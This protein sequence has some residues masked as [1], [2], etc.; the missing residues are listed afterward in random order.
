VLVVIETRAVASS[1]SA[2]RRSPS[3][4]ST[5]S[6]AVRLVQ[7]QRREFVHPASSSSSD[8]T[9]PADAWRES[10]R[11]DENR[12]HPSIAPQP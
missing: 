2:R 10:I 7:E 1:S 3:P 9:G 6:I 5:L 11:R 4:S 12:M 8:D